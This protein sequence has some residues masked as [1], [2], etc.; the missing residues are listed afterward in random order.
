MSSDDPLLGGSGRAGFRHLKP[1]VLGHLSSAKAGF[2][3]P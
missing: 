2:F 3:G 1:R